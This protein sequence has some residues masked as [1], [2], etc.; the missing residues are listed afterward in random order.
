MFTDRIGA[1]ASCRHF[2]TGA[3]LQCIDRYCAQVDS[4]TARVCGRATH[5]SEV[6]CRRARGHGSRPGWVVRQIV[7]ILTV[8]ASYACR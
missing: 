6:V 8:S 4:G 1:G 7:T 3:V 2:G 5:V